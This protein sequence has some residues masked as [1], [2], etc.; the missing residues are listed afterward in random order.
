MSLSR[1]WGA[2]LVLADGRSA[3]IARMFSPGPRR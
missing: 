1:G 3:R 2:V